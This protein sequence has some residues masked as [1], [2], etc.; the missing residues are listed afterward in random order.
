MNTVEEL[1]KLSEKACRLEE[2]GQL[3]SLSEETTKWH[4]INPFIEVLGYDLIDEVVPEYPIRIGANMTKCD[5]AIKKAGK[6]IMLLEAKEAKKTGR[7]LDEAASQLST[8]FGQE[9]EVWLGI[10]TNGIEYRFYSGDPDGVKKMDPQPFLVLDLLNFDESAAETVSNK[11]AKALFDP[12]KVQKLAQKEKFK[13]KWEPKI[14]DALR[15]ELKE[16]SKELFQL[17]I[18]K[19]GAE[20]EDLERLKPLVKKVANQMPSSVATSPA[21]PGTLS[22][23]SG[24]NES[25]IPIRWLE[26][27]Q[28]YQAFLIQDGK[29]R[30]DNGSIRSVSRACIELGPNPS[31]NG[32]DEW[33]YFDLRD[34]KWTPIGTLRGLSDKEQ[35]ERAG[36]SM[37]SV[38]SPFR[39][40]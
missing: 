28:T 37:G 39:K 22:P 17:L 9:P 32:W 20:T 10:L 18:N 4:L 13:R 7:T 19:V 6:T 16:P 23:P 31:Y 3:Q 8:Y 36:A 40:Y 35:I 33:E 12:N 5:Y 34:Q 21:S 15:E 27:G 11:F 25:G 38:R 1:R 2:K 26:L 24:S 29:V 14:L 30:L